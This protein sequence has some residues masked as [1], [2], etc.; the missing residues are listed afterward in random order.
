MFHRLDL[1]NRAELFKLYAS[2]YEDNNTHDNTHNNIIFRI[3]SLILSMEKTY[4]LSNECIKQFNLFKSDLKMNK[5]LKD[6][7][8]LSPSLYEIFM[9]ISEILTS[10]RI[11][12]NEIMN[13][14]SK[15]ENKSNN[16]ITLPNSMSDFV[17]EIKKNVDKYNLTNE[18]KEIIKKYWNTSGKLVKDYRD[19][20]QHFG[21][22]FEKALINDFKNP[23]LIILLPD[24]PNVKSNKK[25]T[26]YKKINALEFIISEFYAL[27]NLINNVSEYYNYKDRDF[28][29]NI[30]INEK[31]PNSLSIIFDPNR[32]Y[33]QGFETYIE[34]K[35]IYSSN[36][37]LQNIDLKQF[38]FLKLPIFFKNKH[39]FE[40]DYTLV[41]E[42]ENKFKLY[43]NIDNT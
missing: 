24:N 7:H 18:L 37:L 3:S 15:Q 31:N 32:N 6:I 19:I 4:E 36:H 27:E 29:F 10:I 25:F 39:S 17:K 38:S 26:F 16:K 40:K 14:I 13:A 35:N 22:L 34:H 2:W 33:L 1:A 30:I 20:D 41:T 11:L 28:D 5:N 21:F 12:Q 9:N 43:D 42:D 8:F 23:K